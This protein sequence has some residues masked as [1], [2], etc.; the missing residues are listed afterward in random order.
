MVVDKDLLSGGYGYLGMMQSMNGQYAPAE[1][2]LKKA[3]DLAPNKQ[4]IG[5][6]AFYDA[7]LSYHGLRARGCLF[8]Q[9][10]CWESF[11]ETL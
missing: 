10:C 8:L 1:N 2:S 3:I 5:L 9:S 4:N 11:A 7:F 6:Q